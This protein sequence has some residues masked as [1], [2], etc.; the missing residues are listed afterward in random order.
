MIVTKVKR[1]RM[2][3]KVEIRQHE[4]F[5]PIEIRLPSNVTRITGIVVTASSTE[6]AIP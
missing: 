4:R 2:V 3:V 6:L 1:K 5:K